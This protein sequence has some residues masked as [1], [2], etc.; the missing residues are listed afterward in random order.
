MCN[1]QRELLREA[2]DQTTPRLLLHGHWH[3]RHTSLLHRESRP[4]VRVE[5]LACDSDGDDAFLELDL[6]AWK[7]PQEGPPHL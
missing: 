7:Q 2:V 6:D 5:G 1:E 3:Y 4:P